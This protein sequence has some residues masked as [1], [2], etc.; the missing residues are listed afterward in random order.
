LAA[1]ADYA[2]AEADLNLQVAKQYPDVH[3]GPG[4]AWNNGNAGDN[5]WILGV[6][7]EIPILDQNQGPI[8][9]AEATRKLSAAKFTALQ[10]Q[11]IS[12]IDSAVAGLHVAREQL[13]NGT[14]AYAFQQQQQKSIQA[15]VD[16]GAAEQ[17]DLLAA[18]LELSSTELARLDNEAKLQTAIATLEDALQQPVATLPAVIERISVESPRAKESQP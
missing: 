16:A 7:M 10:A 12:Q 1:L 13:E 8:A 2:A 4:Y 6:N 14:Q 18:K 3:I 11:V 17:I 15:Q 5:Q 9:E